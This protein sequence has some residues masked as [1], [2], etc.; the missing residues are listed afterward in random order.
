MTLT[1]GL[2]RAAFEG[3]P[4]PEDRTEV[5]RQLESMKGRLTAAG[6][7]D[8]ATHVKERRHWHWCL[9][10]SQPPR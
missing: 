3:M 4:L 9:L 8:V 7:R 2:L 10:H 1:G 5:F 6:L